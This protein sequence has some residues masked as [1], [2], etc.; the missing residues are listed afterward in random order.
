MS[1]KTNFASWE[2]SD[3]DEI[4]REMELITSYEFYAELFNSVASIAAIINKNRQI[5]FTN[6]A[7][8]DMLGLDSIESLLGKRPGETISCIHAIEGEFGCGTVEACR[9]CGAIQ[10]VLECGKL[11]KSVTKETRIRSLLDGKSVSYDLAVTAVP[12]GFKGYDFTVITL[13]DI[14]GEKRKK[15]LERI[16]FHDLANSVGGINGLL[17]LLKSFP[18]K[19]AAPDLLDLSVQASGD[20]LEDITSFRQLV[21]AEAGDLAVERERVNA[22][23]MM[24]SACTRI[25]HHDTAVAKSIRMDASFPDREIVTDRSLLTRVLMNMLLNAVEA[26]PEKGTVAMGCDELADGRLRFRVKNPGVIPPEIR[27]QIFQRSFSTKGENRGLGTYSMKL[28]GETYL[29]G[30]VG[31]DSAPDTDTVFF[32]ELPAELPPI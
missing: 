2:R 14:S 3:A 25:M 23:Q 31:F 18:D 12:L 22:G 1:G 11:G 9:Y 19:N 27:M 5:I 15:G 30:R 28:I 4:R 32:I 16:F 26:S 24:E 17:K 6:Q 7:Y 20:L 10:A 21:L 8:L 13:R 29:R